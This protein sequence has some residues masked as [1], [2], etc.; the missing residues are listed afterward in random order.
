MKNFQRNL[1]IVLAIGLC[2]TCAYQWYLQAV[3]LNTIEQLDQ[4]IYKKSA[5]IQGYT[6]SIHAMD[7][8][9]NQLHD[10]ITQLKQAAVSND[11]WAITEKRE[12]AR[13]QSGG[14]LMSNEIIQYKAAV[15][16]LTNKL[17][18]AYDG[19]K[20]LAAQRDEFVKKLN[21]S[22]KAQNDLTAKYNDLVD[23]FNKLQA[24][25]TN[26]PAK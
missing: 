11:Q 2:G 3:Q 5:D 7:A 18:E 25:A 19:E 23:R 6:N 24:T 22:I 14:D 1:F 26:A 9:I 8:E 13:L 21:D 17:K 15:D 20:E 16:G 4:V 10:R 12:V